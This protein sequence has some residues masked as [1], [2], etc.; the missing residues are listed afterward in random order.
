MYVAWG[1]GKTIGPKHRRSVT[2]HPAY[3][4]PQCAHPQT[5]AGVGGL[6]R[7]LSVGPLSLWAGEGHGGA[8][9]TLGGNGPADG[10]ASGAAL[11][12]PGVLDT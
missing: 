9:L 3:L 1:S 7:R 12:L 11:P 5:G 8:P 6:E 10:K 2:L 4:W